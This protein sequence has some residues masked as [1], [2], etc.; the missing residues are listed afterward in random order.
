VRHISPKDAADLDATETREWLDS[1]DYVLQSG[2]PTKV[3]RLLRELTQ[4][5]RQNG[6]KLPFTANT[7]YVNT[8]PADEQALMPGDPDIERR[9]KSLVR[10]NAAAMVVYANRPRRHQRP[11]LD[12][13][14]GRDCTKSFQSLLPRTRLR[15]PRCDLLQGHAAPDLRARTSK[16]GSTDV[17]RTS[18]RAE[19]RRRPL[20]VSAPL[21]D[22]DFWDYPGSMGLIPSWRLPGAVHP[23]PRRS[24]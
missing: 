12:V 18:P 16:V 10:W 8:I 6:V 11:H 4:Y 19:G 24:A 21:A 17:P 3:A 2:G 13:C 23:L 15:R 14:F 1:V 22:P 20:V 5:A 7:P 9:I